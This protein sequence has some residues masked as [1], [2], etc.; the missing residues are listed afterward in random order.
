[1]GREGV[2]FSKGRTFFMVLMLPSLESFWLLV[3]WLVGR[4]VGY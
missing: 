3:V 2:V 1:M 4:L